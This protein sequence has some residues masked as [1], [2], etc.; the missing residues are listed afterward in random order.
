MCFVYLV[1]TVVL[2]TEDKLQRKVVEFFHNRDRTDD[3]DLMFITGT[4]K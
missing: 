3:T 4:A 2:V 1:K